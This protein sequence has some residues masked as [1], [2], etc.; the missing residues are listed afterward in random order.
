MCVKL[1]MNGS[2][3]PLC[4]NISLVCSRYQLDRNDI[5]SSSYS[6]YFPIIIKRM[7]Y[8]NLTNDDKATVQFAKELI[9]SRDYRV[10]NLCDYVIILLCDKLFFVFTMYYVLRVR[11]KSAFM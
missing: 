4:S 8:I 2:C 3:S 11:N 1:A 5:A 9:S 6:T 10:I 7:Y